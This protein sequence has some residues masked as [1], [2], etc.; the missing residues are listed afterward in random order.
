MK[1][2]STAIL[3]FWTLCAGVGFTEK[4]VS[5]ES[6][7]KHVVTLDRVAWSERDGVKDINDQVDDLPLLGGFT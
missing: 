3:L 1:N 6:L 7:W 2:I 4:W 5:N